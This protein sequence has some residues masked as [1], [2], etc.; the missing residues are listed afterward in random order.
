MLLATVDDDIIG[1]NKMRNKSLV[2]YQF[3]H[4]RAI[5]I[6]KEIKENLR[7]HTKNKSKKIWAIILQWA[8]YVEKSNIAIAIIISHFVLVWL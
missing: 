4:L 6:E 7:N 2:H 3:V 5:S 8:I 1:N